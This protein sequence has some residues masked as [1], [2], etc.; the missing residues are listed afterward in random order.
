ML[1]DE[2]RK[3]ER[4][5]GIVGVLLHTFPTI[6]HNFRGGLHVSDSGKIRLGGSLCLAT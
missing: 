3:R 2:R 1:K 5:R 6:L 4:E